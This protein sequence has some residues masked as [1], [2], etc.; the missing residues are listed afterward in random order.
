[1]GMVKSIGFVT[2]FPNINSNEDIFV[3]ECVVES[4]MLNIGYYQMP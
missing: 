2:S 3:I 1:M 4:N